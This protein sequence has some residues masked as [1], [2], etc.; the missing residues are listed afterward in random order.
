MRKYILQVRID[1]V[2]KYQAI[3]WAR[4]ASDTPAQ[5]QAKV[6]LFDKIARCASSLSN[7]IARGNRMGGYRSQTLVDRYNDLR[8]EAIHAGLWEGYCASKQASPEHDAYDF[9]A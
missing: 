8:S 9:F 5:H 2:M 1:S 7:H 6:A 4:D 3:L